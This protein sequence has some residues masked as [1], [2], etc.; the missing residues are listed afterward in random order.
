MQQAQYFLDNLPSPCN[1]YEP[2]VKTL[3]LS[4]KF[5]QY[6]MQCSPNWVILEK[7]YRIINVW[8]KNQK[9]G[10]CTCWIAFRP[11]TT[12]TEQA[13]TCDH[14]SSSLIF[15]QVWYFSQCAHGLNCMDQKCRS[16]AI[17]ICIRIGSLVNFTS[18]WNLERRFCRFHRYL[19]SYHW[20]QNLQIE[21]FW[22]MYTKSVLY[23]TK[24]RNSPCISC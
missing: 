18:V 20:L 3:Q 13:G 1:S 19:T 17:F 5:N 7:S 14:Q 11:T 6:S 22:P 4:L 8:K 24:I 10:P 12:Y 15:P 9:L 23:Q 2:W 21:L 16:W